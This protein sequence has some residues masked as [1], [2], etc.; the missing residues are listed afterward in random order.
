MIFSAFVGFFLFLAPA[1]AQTVTVSTSNSPWAGDFVG[2]GTCD[3]VQINQ[4]IAAL[5]A[6]GG[7][8]RLAPGNYDI[9][10]GTDPLGGIFINQDNVI[11]SGE[12]P[13]TLLRL[14]DDQDTNVI[15]ITGNGRKNVTI[16]DL[17]CDGNWTTNDRA[18][19]QEMAFEADCVRGGSSINEAQSNIVVENVH[20]FDCPR[21][22]VMLFAGVNGE[23]NVV[24]NSKFGDA[25][26]DVVELLGNGGIISGN[27]A[28]IEA[29]TG[30]VFGGDSQD[31][32]T[33]VNNIVRIR[34]AGVVNT[35]IFRTYPG[36]YRTIL[37]GNIVIGETGSNVNNV[38]NLQNY[39]NVVTGNAFAPA[40]RTSSHMC[41]SVSTTRACMAFN[42]AT[43]ITGNTI[44]NIQMQFSDTSGTPSW[45]VRIDD[46]LIGNTNYPSGAGVSVG[47]NLTPF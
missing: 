11:L 24:R 44:Q 37:T 41:G 34:P 47:T 20:F 45:G 18:N 38:T 33:I 26:S 16:R 23:R 2:D 21:L 39:I 46:N 6:I 35:T 10:R 29:T 32:L 3:E 13:A 17:A 7:E 22:C 9:C 28:V 5:P 36:H 8:V 19:E 12:G 25:R 43:V 30:H 15:R 40:V 27:E 4:A 42:G 1:L 31:E 14:A